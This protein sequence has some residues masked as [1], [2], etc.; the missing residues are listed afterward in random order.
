MLSTFFVC[1][2][3][4]NTK[5]PFCPPGIRHDSMFLGGLGC[6]SSGET[7]ESLVEEDGVKT[8]FARHPA[9]PT[10]HCIALVR[11]QAGE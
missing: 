8:T 1:Q 3:F 5:Y 4:I 7:L 2:W 6:D 10:G 9:L 11:G